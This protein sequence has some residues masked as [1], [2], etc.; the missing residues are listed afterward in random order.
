M[1]IKTTKDIEMLKKMKEVAELQISKCTSSEDIEDIGLEVLKI[2][3]RLA[4]L[5]EEDGTQRTK[6]FL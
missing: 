3:M 1:Y 5:E 6:R 2:D 4:E